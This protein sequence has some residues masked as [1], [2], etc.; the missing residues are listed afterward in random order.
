MYKIINYMNDNNIVVASINE[1][2]DNI[3][4]DIVDQF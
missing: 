4:N 3:I 1:N 2:Y